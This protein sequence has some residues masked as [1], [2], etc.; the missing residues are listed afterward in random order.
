[1]SVFNFKYFSIHQAKSS[2]K[3]GTDAML[4][5]A[6]VDV[7]AQRNALDIGAGTGVISLMMAQRNNELEITAV[8]IDQLAAEECALNFT[9]SSWN[10]RLTVIH[11]DIASLTTETRFDL[12]VSNPPYYS[13]TLENND[14]RKAQSR[15]V[16]ALPIDDF[17]VKSTE[18]L[19]EQGDVWIIVPFSDRLKWINSAEPSHLFLK[20]SI[21]ISGKAE[22]PPNRIILHF[23][24]EAT[25]SAAH[26]FTVRNA[27]GSYTEE[28]RRLT[29]DYHSKAI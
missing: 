2:M 21:V 3:V 14:E 17:F 12:I 9:R 5:G 7:S 8:E 6:F 11:L 26:Y 22:I 25:V 19:S 23:S 15:H 28:Y 13:S 27:D 16:S 20:E 1:M 24:R 18:L 4:L 29:I 10:D